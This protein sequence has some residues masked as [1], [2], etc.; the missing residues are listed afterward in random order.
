METKK[1]SF[2]EGLRW[3]ISTFFFTS[4]FI[5]AIIL[6]IILI[7]ALAII[8]PVVWLGLFIITLPFK[9]AREAVNGFFLGIIQYFYLGF[10]Y[11][12]CDVCSFDGSYY[13]TAACQDCHAESR[14][15]LYR[16]RNNWSK[17]F[18]GFE[19][20]FTPAPTGRSYDGQDMTYYG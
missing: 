14:K 1:E 4:G 20:R 3:R 17:W 15:D 13:C 9:K 12:E 2:I 19:K 8:S 6:G 18:G 10:N 5:G 7:I 11:D 16:R